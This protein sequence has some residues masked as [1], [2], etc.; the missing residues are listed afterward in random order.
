MA[1]K[2]EKSVEFNSLQDWMCS[3]GE[4]AA[5][6]IVSLILSVLMVAAALILKVVL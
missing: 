1:Q 2:K 4:P 6:I 3:L 5:S